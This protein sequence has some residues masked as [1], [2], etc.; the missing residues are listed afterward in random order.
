MTERRTDHPAV[1]YPALYQEMQ[2][3]KDRHWWFKVHYRAILDIIRPYLKPGMVVLDLGSAGGWSTDGLPSD[4]TRILFDIR[5]LAL[6]INRSRV[7]ARV[8][9]DAHNVPLKDGICDLV[10]CEGL[11]HQSEAEDPRRIMREAVRL[12]RAGGLVLVAEPAFS[13]LFGRH[14]ELFGGCRRFTTGELA[15]LFSGQPV[16]FIRKTYLHLFAFLHLWIVRKTLNREATDLSLEN[17]VTNTVNLWLG[18]MER[19]LTRRVSMPFGVTAALLVR[20]RQEESR[21]GAQ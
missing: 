1:N 9:G 13:C 11:L 5:H 21:E 18:T 15:A 12:V 14:D 7:F 17:P 10:I 3:L 19:W 6:K 4:T 8:C 16:Q 2:R 20:R